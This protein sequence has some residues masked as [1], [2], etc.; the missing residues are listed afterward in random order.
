MLFPVLCLKN[1]LDLELGQRKRDNVGPQGEDASH[2]D[3]S[4]LPSRRDTGN[5]RT[6]PRS[7]AGLACVPM[8]VILVGICENDQGTLRRVSDDIPC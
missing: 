5:Q 4:C 7:A 3:H 2:I 6:M 1:K 8:V